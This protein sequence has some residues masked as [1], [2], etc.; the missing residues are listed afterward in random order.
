MRKAIHEVIPCDVHEQ[1]PLIDR[2]YPPFDVVLTSCCLENACPDRDSFQRVIAKVGGLIK[3]RG[4]L[5]IIGDLN[6][7]YYMVGAE[8][9]FSLKLDQK[10]VEETVRAAGFE[11]LQFHKHATSGEFSDANG[12]FFL[13]AKKL[14]E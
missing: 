14:A 6:K 9:F 1:N 4:H 13:A 10:F 7:G 12:Y 11:M 5:L 2:V 3:P 8:P